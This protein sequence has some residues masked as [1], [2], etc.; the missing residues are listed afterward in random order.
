MG[1]AIAII[2]PDDWVAETAV[3]NPGTMWPARA[4]A[5]EHACIIIITGMQ[6]QHTERGGRLTAEF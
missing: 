5:R 6:V 3:D 4:Q 2:L 1:I